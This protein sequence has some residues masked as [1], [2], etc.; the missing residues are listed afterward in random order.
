MLEGTKRKLDVSGQ[1]A[2][3][4]GSFCGYWNWLICD[5]IENHYGNESWSRDPTISK[6]ADQDFQHILCEYK[7][8]SSARLSCK[9]LEMSMPRASFSYFAG[10]AM[11]YHAGRE[12]E[13]LEKHCGVKALRRL[14]TQ[15][16]KSDAKMELAKILCK[17]RW[18]KGSAGQGCRKEKLLIW[19]TL[20][21][22]MVYSLI[23]GMYMKLF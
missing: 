22:L 21:P 3:G 13:K 5:F 23:G 7:C 10:N 14:R 16:R 6:W 20:R 9:A 15:R 8:Y 1:K 17:T 2:T 11:R 18:Q 4:E 19:I 12:S